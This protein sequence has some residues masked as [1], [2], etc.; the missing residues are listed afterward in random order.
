[1]AKVR[2]TVNQPQKETDSSCFVA[3]PREQITIV[4]KKVEAIFYLQNHKKAQSAFFSLKLRA[5]VLIWGK[6]KILKKI[7]ILDSWSH[8][9]SLNC[10]LK[11]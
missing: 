9:K 4:Q 5:G 7:L 6:L 10:V 11:L 3:S 8:V 1:M 2:A